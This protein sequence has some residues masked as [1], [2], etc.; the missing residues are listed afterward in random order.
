MIRSAALSSANVIDCINKV[1]MLS[2]VITEMSGCL[3]VYN[4][5]IQPATQVNSAWLFLYLSVAA[6]IACIS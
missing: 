2:R 3:R 4:L 1:N 5:D 6:V